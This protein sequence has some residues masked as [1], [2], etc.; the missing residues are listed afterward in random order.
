[1]TESAEQRLPAPNE[2]RSVQAMV[3]EDLKLRERLGRER[4]G[5]SLQAFNHRDG[6]WDLYEELLDAACYARQ[7]IAERDA[8][9][10]AWARIAELESDNQRQ[11][12]L[13]AELRR[14]ITVDGGLAQRYTSLADPHHHG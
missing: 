1:M 6:L 2:R 11:R 4:Y 12:D 9:S 10:E 8:A 7:L 5:T 3:R 13:V 14:Q